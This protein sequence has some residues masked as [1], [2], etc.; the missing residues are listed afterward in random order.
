MCGGV[1]V[2]FIEREAFVQ[3]KQ[4]YLVSIWSAAAEIR[5]KPLAKE[6]S[7]NSV[8]KHSVYALPWIYTT[9]QIL[10]SYSRTFLSPKPL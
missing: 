2:Y 1:H 5:L 4:Q 3:L 8:L 7:K 6:K 9:V 10:L